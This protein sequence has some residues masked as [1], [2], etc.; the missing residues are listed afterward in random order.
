MLSSNTSLILRNA[1]IFY[2]ISEKAST[3]RLLL[4]STLTLKLLFLLELVGTQKFLVYGRGGGV[5]HLINNAKWAI[6]VG[7]LGACSR[8]MLEIDTDK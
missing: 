7:D 8:K 4:L 6:V 2:R 5:A 3:N 1:F